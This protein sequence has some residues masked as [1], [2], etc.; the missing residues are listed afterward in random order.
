[1]STAALA[2]YRRIIHNGRP[3]Y[4]QHLIATCLGC[5]EAILSIERMSEFLKVMADEIDMVRY[6]EPLVARFGGG[7]ETGISGVQLI[8]TSAIVIHTNDAHR[9][10]Y[11]DVF[12][13][14]S[15][16]EE[17]V[18]RVLDEFLLPT[19]VDCEVMY[20]K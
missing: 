2:E 20:R 8:E 9:D 15:F 12:S 6:G 5:N 3:H 4:G 17:T 14:K 7:I 18:R 10:M 13:C 19:S 11:L 16:K 1:M